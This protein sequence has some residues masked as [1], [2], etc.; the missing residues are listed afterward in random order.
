MT[1]RNKRTQETRIISVILKPKYV[2]PA[3]K[4]CPK[5]SELIISK[6]PLPDCVPDPVT[7]NFWESRDLPDRDEFRFSK[8]LRGCRTLRKVL[9][10]V[11]ERTPVVFSH[12]DALLL[13]EDRGRGPR[14]IDNIFQKT[15]AGIDSSVGVQGNKLSERIC[16]QSGDIFERWEWKTDKGQVMDWWGLASITDPWTLWDSR[17]RLVEKWLL[18]RLRDRGKLGALP[19]MCGWYKVGCFQ[20]H[21]PAG[22]EILHVVIGYMCEG[23]T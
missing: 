10:D 15:M 22:T 19:Q 21:E 9:V 14:N 20:A 16:T 13:F 3:L 7:F 5:L 6:I 8:W 1:T 23:D 11:R 4:Q 18:S 2:E 17:E 12:S